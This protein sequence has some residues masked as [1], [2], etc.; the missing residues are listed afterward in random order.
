MKCKFCQENMP[1]N[2]GSRSPAGRQKSSGSKIVFLGGGGWR[3]GDH[4]PLSAG[5]KRQMSVG[6]ATDLR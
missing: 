3:R 2:S 5:R 4:Q 6:R 1:P